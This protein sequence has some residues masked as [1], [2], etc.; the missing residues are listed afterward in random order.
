MTVAPRVSIVVAA[1]NVASYI[2]RCVGSL[3][4]QTEGSI[5]VI[6]VDDGSTDRTAALADQFASADSRVRT[7]HRPNGGLSV[8]RNTGLAT[9]T[10]EFICFIDG[11]DWVDREMVASMLRSIETAASDVA[12]AGAWVDFHDNEERLLRSEL[13][14]M[15]PRLI[16]RGVPVRPYSCDEEF[17][18]LVGYAWNKLYR[19]DWL[20]ETGFRFEPDL[21]LIEDIDFNARVLALAERIVTVPEAF[22]HY[23]QRPRLS[24][25]T[26]FDESLLAKRWR[27]IQ[28]VDSLLRV[29]GVGSAE[30]SKRSARASGLSA[31]M[32]LRVAS[33][34]PR[35]APHLS[36]MLRSADAQRLLAQARNQQASGWRGRWA[37]ATLARQWYAVGVAP[38]RAVGS[39]SGLLSA[40]K[41]IARGRSR[42][43]G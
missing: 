18:N 24:L 12:I 22:V 40:S 30:R 26:A 5:E 27:A 28:C 23:V 32:A 31:W 7:I 33:A 19:R 14:S 20:V 2:S 42:A 21:V 25:G 16:V 11:D 1:Y 10:G 13:R 29:W 6:V 8:A 43:D 38:M 15:T 37:T 35:P 39:F 17:I 41:R 34:A 9:A 36:A 4:E 3:L